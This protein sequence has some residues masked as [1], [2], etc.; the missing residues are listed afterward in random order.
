MLTPLQFLEVLS[1]CAST[2]ANSTRNQGRRIKTSF[3]HY[4]NYRG[5]DELIF[6]SLL[7]KELLDHGIPLE[8]IALEY[9]PPWNID[10]AWCESGI[11][12]YYVSSDKVVLVEISPIYDE[13]RGG[14]LRKDEDESIGED[15]DHVALAK[16]RVGVVLVPFLGRQAAPPSIPPVWR[17]H[18]LTK[19]VHLIRC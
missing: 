11:C 10:L 1:G 19:K 3:P 5:E 17:T 18:A 4:A 16:G 8:A 12:K 14:G 13:K 6:R 9:L 15:I 7:F 2:A